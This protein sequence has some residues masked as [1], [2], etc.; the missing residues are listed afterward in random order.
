MAGRPRKY[1]LNPP[2]GAPVVSG[3]P[4]SDLVEITCIKHNVH[5]GDGRELHWQ[6]SAQVVPELAEF[7]IERG[8]VKR[9][10]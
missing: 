9:G 5:L 2:M 10:K 6:E 7:L 8:R 4:K 1:S 3:A